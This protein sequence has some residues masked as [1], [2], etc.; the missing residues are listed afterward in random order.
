[1]YCEKSWVTD[2]NPWVPVQKTNDL[3]RVFVWKCFCLFD[4]KLLLNLVNGRW[5]YSFVVG[6]I[7]DLKPQVTGYFQ[8][9]LQVAR[10][11]FVRYT[12]CWE[13]KLLCKVWGQKPL[14]FHKALMQSI[15]CIY[16]TG[17]ISFQV[18]FDSTLVD[19]AS[20]LTSLS[21]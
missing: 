5:Y 6:D 20:F 10:S 19:L 16:I 12:G 1:M 11:I 17:Q 7:T 14:K 4:Q 8:N 15:E 18:Y 3:F 21:P 13:A 9:Q 2:Q